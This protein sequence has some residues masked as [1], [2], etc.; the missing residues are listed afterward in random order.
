MSKKKFKIN[1]KRIAFIL[2]SI[3]IFYFLFTNIKLT[4][5]YEIIKQDKN[6]N[7]LGIGQQKVK[8]KDGYFTT[9]TTIQENKKTYKEYKQNGEAS[10]SNNEYW[11]GTMADNG[12][13]ITALSVILSGYNKDYTPEDLRQKYYPVMNYDE[14]Q[15]ELE[16]NFG[17]ESSDFYYDVSHLS[18]GYITNHLKSNRPILICVWSKP[19]K[20]RW[21]SS[22]HYMVLLATD[23]NNMVYVSNPIRRKK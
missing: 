22:S 23:D 20:N 3:F 5:D 1:Y 15:E 6:S 16:N 11:D 7:Y 21:T 4:N 17:I 2:F 13:G 14:I 8:N 10:W 18:N 19:N 12:C 9:F